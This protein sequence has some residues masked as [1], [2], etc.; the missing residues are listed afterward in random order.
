M[1]K[2]RKYGKNKLKNAEK[3]FY[4][5]GSSKFYFAAGFYFAFDKK[6]KN[7]ALA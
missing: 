2:Q 4:T 6:N 7:P 1:G 5:E 3:G